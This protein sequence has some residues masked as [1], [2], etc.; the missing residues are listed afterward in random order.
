[1][2]E[3]IKLT[4][5][6]LLMFLGAIFTFGGSNTPSRLIGVIGLFAAIFNAFTYFGVIA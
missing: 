2:N 6:I 3:A 5:I 1:M 4:S